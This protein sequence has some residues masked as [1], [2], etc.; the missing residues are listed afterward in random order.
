MVESSTPKD[1]EERKEVEDD[2]IIQQ[3]ITKLYDS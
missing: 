2:E 1:R 3:Q